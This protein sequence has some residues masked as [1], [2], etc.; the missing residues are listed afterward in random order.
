MCL[1][2]VFG[3]KQD[4]FD[5]EMVSVQTERDDM[6]DVKHKVFEPDRVHV[7]SRKHTRFSVRPLPE[8]FVLQEEG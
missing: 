3:T 7:P 1:I 8:G 4:V 2:R 6:S 5:V